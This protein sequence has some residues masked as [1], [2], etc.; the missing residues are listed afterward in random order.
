M[1]LDVRDAG[2]GRVSWIDV[3]RPGELPKYVSTWPQAAE[4]P[5]ETDDTPESKLPSLPAAAQVA[6]LEASEPS[7][8]SEPVAPPPKKHRR[9]RHKRATSTHH[10]I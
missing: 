5:K 7:D 2:A 3:S 4:G 1:H 9:H 6:P 8:S 10:T